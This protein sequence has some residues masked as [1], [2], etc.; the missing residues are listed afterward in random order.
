[1]TATATREATVF[2][3]TVELLSKATIA[4]DGGAATADCP[5][6]GEA[7]LTVTPPAAGTT[8]P[9]LFCTSGCDRTALYAHV[10][11]LIY[12]HKSQAPGDH[13]P[14]LNGSGPQPAEDDQADHQPGS[15]S[16]ASDAANAQQSRQQR[17]AAERRAAKDAKAND[18]AE[19]PIPGLNSKHY[20][21]L[22]KGSGIPDAIITERGYRSIEPCA[23]DAKMLKDAGFAK[24]QYIGKAGWYA[25]S[26]GITGEK[27]TGQFKPD[28]PRFSESGRPIKYES[29]PKQPNHFDVHPRNTGRRHDANIPVWFTEGL[30]KGDS[31]TGKGA[32]AIALTGVFNFLT[33]VDGSMGVPVP[34]FDEL[35][36]RRAPGKRGAKPTPREFVLAFDSDAWRNKGVYNAMTRL[37]NL[38]E[39]RG[40]KVG[41]LYLPDKPDGS[42][43][44]VDDFLAAGHA[45]DDLWALVSWTMRPLPGS[46]TDLDNGIAGDA[47]LSTAFEK[48]V[49]AI[50]GIVVAGLNL[51]AGKPK[52][53]KSWW[54]LQVAIAVAAGGT[55]FGKYPVAQ[56]DVLYLAL[57]EPPYATQERMVKLMAALGL[58]DAQR[59]AMGRITFFHE[60]PRLGEGGDDKLRLWLT[61]HPDTRLVIVDTLVK[62]R[63][64]KE[65]GKGGGGMYQ[66]DYDN[67]DPLKAIAQDFKVPL[68]AAHHKNKK[69]MGKDTDDIL[70]T[71]TSSTGTTGSADALLILDRPRLEAM[72]TLTITGRTVREDA[73]DLEFD[74]DTNLWTMADP[75]ADADDGPELTDERRQVLVA[76]GNGLWKPAELVGP[77]DKPVQSVRNLLNRMRQAKLVDKATDGEWF[78]MPKGQE[79]IAAYAAERLAAAAPDGA[80][81]EGAGQQRKEG[82]KG[83]KSE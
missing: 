10:A 18:A 41:I 31:L 6:C 34:D 70:D 62:L 27:Q 67:A 48:P 36:Y 57:E 72:G 21:E 5:V 71:I 54:M 83:D 43:Q 73:F 12:R 7:T 19:S 64:R 42:K 28:S 56:G 69:K 15:G 20:R 23:D 4:P 47:L 22:S 13:A 33:T 37:K 1:M 26:Y 38:I 32:F 40:G 46:A 49:F 17:R 58:T 45:L 75:S 9:A 77:L 63:A 50:D 39:M 25:D 66:D 55:A 8:Q 11:R 35:T 60:W 30:K 74:P 3:K 59:A 52:I 81:P 53:G 80:S 68:V 76:M 24:A 65:H 78:V 79:V 61:K 51:L 2:Q 29:C 14:H 16:A 82:E 44:G